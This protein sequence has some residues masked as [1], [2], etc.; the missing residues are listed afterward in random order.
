V[1]FRKN[2]LGAAFAPLYDALKPIPPWL[3]LAGMVAFQAALV[4]VALFPLWLPLA[5]HALPLIAWL[6]GHVHVS[7]QPLIGA[8]PL[9]LTAIAAVNPVPQSLLTE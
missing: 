3:P 4:S 6:P 7:R 8:L 2:A 9:L 1:P 5:F